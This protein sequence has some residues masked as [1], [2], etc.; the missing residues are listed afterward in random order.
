M[1]SVNMRK[2]MN[3]A[4]SVLPSVPHGTLQGEHYTD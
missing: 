2:Y 3:T 4:I 1:V